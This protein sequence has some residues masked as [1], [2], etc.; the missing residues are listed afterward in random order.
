MGRVVNFLIFSNQLSGTLP[1]AMVC[2]T[3]MTRVRLQANQLSGTL[4]DVLG[5][6]LSGPCSRDWNEYVNVIGVIT[7]QVKIITGNLVTLENL[8]HSKLPLPLPS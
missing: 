1:D 3:W 6:M 2:M 8:F 5:S 4:P 7:V